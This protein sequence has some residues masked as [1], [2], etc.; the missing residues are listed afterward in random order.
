MIVRMYGPSMGN[1]SFARITIGMR[2]ALGRLGSLGGHYPSDREVWEEYVAGA[3]ADVAVM[4]GS[5]K[6]VAMIK[7]CGMHAE[8]HMLIAPNSD[9]LPGDMVSAVTEC[10]TGV[11]SP[12]RWG[13]DVLRAHF[14]LP[15]SVWQHGVDKGFAPVAGDAA[16]RTFDY[17]DKR[18]TVGHMASSTRQRKGTVELLTAWMKFVQERPEIKDPCLRVVFAST[19][20]GEALALVSELAH[21]RQELIRT[22]I[23][24]QYQ[25]MSVERAARWYGKL[26]LLCQPSRGEGFGMTPLESRACGVPIAATECTGHSEGHVRGR[27][28]I[29]IPHGDL[30]PIDDG[31]GAM[32]PSVSSDAVLEALHTAYEQWPALSWAA[33]AA[34]DD[35]REA[36]SWEEVTRRWINS[37]ERR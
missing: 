3:C 37:M 19:N 34:A 21:G 12:S 14:K 13:A 33:Q 24:S 22:V 31:P 25:D 29:I 1:A 16:A 2:D 7:T 23:V 5:P 8:R 4:T 36:W 17:A 9:W 30:S 27:G 32:A 20:S 35:V 28:A 15:V 11:I 18:F 10:C 26:H 6:H